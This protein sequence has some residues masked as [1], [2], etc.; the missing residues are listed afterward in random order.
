[1]LLWLTGN[2]LG[3]LPVYDEL[4]GQ[5][6]VLVVQLDGHLDI[7]RFRDTTRE[8]SHGNFLLHCAGPLP[9]VINVGHRDLLLPPEYVAKHFRQTIAAGDL[10]VNGPAVLQ[11][12][13]GAAGTAPKVILDLDCDVFDPAYFP[14]VAEP[15]PFGLAPAQVLAVLEVIPADRL[16]GVLISEF[17]PG[18]DQGDRSLASV[19]W[20]LEYLLLRRYEL[21]RPLARQPDVART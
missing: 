11:Q 2:H 20:L 3:T 14:A 5:K 16:A 1:M 19:M 12:L 17:A 21:G 10:A 8:L 6:D 13:R 9:P 18:R 4:A 7:H 15:V